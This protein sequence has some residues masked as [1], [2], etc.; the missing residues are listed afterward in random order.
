MSLP[1]ETR[2]LDLPP[3]A[4]LVQVIQ[5]GLEKNFKEVAVSVAECPDLTKAPYNL[6]GS[7][8]SGSP[9]I[10]DLGGPMYLLPLPDLEKNYRF[11]D[12]AKC[13]E[14]PNSFMMGAGAGP[15]RIVG[16]NSEMMPNLC[17]GIHASNGSKIAKMKG[18]G[19]EL[20]AL[21]PDHAQCSLMAN[22]F[23]SEGKSGPVLKIKA[24]VRT[25][26]ENFV[27]CIR[28]AIAEK[29]PEKVIGLG[30]FFRMVTGSAKCHIMPNIPVI[31]LNSD[32]EVG[33]WLKYFD[34]PAPMV[35]FSVLVSS[36]PGLDLRLE[37][38][39]GYGATSGGH[40]H[41]DVTPDI[42]EYEAYYNLA[43][44]LYRIDRPTSDKGLGK[45]WSF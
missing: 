21:G 41:Y 40:Y 15:H 39:H 30:G 18:D 29:F 20:V 27:S 23:A 26:E 31:P 37:H 9:R 45:I 6:Q 19:H 5:S 10:G 14:L 35:F 43:E 25:G 36:D 24:R 8:L 13:M 12:L 4:E 44:I 16:T 2:K 34:L 28:Q 3:L 42:V 22:L 32:E 33:K 11:D 17:T 7:G 1:V 38:S